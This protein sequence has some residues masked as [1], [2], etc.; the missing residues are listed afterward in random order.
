MIF[1][2]IAKKNW[3]FF[4]YKIYHK[5]FNPPCII[6]RP[7]IYPEFNIHLSTLTRGLNAQK[8]GNKFFIILIVLTTIFA[9]IFLCINYQLENE[10]CKNEISRAR[11][12][13]L[14]LL[15][16]VLLS[17]LLQPQLI[18]SSSRLRASGSF[19][20]FLQVSAALHFRS[21]FV[22]VFILYHILFS[23]GQD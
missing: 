4:R 16:L 3:I 12:W 2:R 8:Y 18:M 9:R 1:L 19:P 17:P 20:R 7:E 15:L 5:K 6:A 23:G 13:T 21:L 14:L 11:I 22:L 10:M